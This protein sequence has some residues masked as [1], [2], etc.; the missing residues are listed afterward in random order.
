M[1]LREA[2]AQAYSARPGI[3]AVDGPAVSLNNVQ[4]KLLRLLKWILLLLAAQAKPLGRRLRRT[5]QENVSRQFLGNGNY[6][7]DLN[8]DMCSIAVQA[9]GM[10]TTD[11]LIVYGS[12]GLPKATS[13]NT[14]HVPRGVGTSGGTQQLDMPGEEWVFTIDATSL[15]PGQY[16]LK[17]FTNKEEVPLGVLAVADLTFVDATTTTAIPVIPAVPTEPSVT[18]ALL[19]T[20]P[21]GGGGASSGNNSLAIYVGLIG[22]LSGALLGIICILIAGCAYCGWSA[23]RKGFKELKNSDDLNFGGDASSRSSVL[24]R[25]DAGGY[26]RGRGVDIEDARSEL[27]LLSLDP[28]SHL[29]GA[30]S[31][32]RREAMGGGGE[33][34]A[35]APSVND[36]S[37]LGSITRNSSAISLAQSTQCSTAALRLDNGDVGALRAAAHQALANLAQSP[38]GA[39]PSISL[40]GRA[41]AAYGLNAP[42]TAASS[43]SAFEGAGGN[44]F[45][46]PIV[47]R[48]PSSCL[49]GSS[50]AALSSGHSP[51]ISTAVPAGSGVVSH[52]PFD[53]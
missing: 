8:G 22:G 45:Q 28:I 33:P 30:N 31:I 26:H 49:R 29:A 47:S 20:S 24:R 40:N 12:D 44:S 10:K 38:V 14:L 42:R 27:T 1:R 9:V 7:C 11:S 23:R 41:A 35:P 15:D 4:M 19:P 34:I 52:N 18:T 13:T 53:G 36:G 3:D 37:V 25:I 46:L 51:L 6:I 50:P 16:H 2:L 17:V 48:E 5:A 39:S 32:F 43:S 21:G